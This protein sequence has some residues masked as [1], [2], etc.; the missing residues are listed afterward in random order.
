MQAAGNH[1]F[2]IDQIGVNIEFKPNEKKL[3]LIE[4]TEKREFVKE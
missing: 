2:R 3:V 1:V 4:G